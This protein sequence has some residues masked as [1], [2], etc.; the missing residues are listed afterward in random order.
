MTEEDGSS[1][2]RYLS[3]SVSR[4][5]SAFDVTLHNGDCQRDW[6]DAQRI[7]VTHPA[8]EHES[9]LLPFHFWSACSA[10]SRTMCQFSKSITS[11]DINKGMLAS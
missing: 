8:S 2:V 9:L 7:S 11:K 10:A 1:S 5:D 3:R 4:A 6:S